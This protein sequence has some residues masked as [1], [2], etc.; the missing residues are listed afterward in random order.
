VDDP[1]ELVG[2]HFG[3]SIENLRAT[4]RWLIASAGAVVAAIIAGAQ[5]VDYS[6]RSVLGV[7]LAASAVILGLALTLILLAQTA[8]VLTVP[9]PMAT[10]LDRAEFD[11]DAGDINV[12]LSGEMN[13]KVQWII[14]RKSYLL[15]GYD[16]V[17]DLLV[18][19]KTADSE[20]QDKSDDQN[21]AAEL[22]RLERQIDIVEEAAHYR[23]LSNAYDRLIRRF[24]KGSIAFIVSVIL[25][26][27]SGIAGR[28]PDSKPSNVITQPIPVRVFI[29]APSDV[30]ASCQERDGVAIGGDL[31]KP[32]V[33]MPPTPACS[34]ATMS[35]GKSGIVIVPKVPLKGTDTPP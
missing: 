32:I 22:K 8:R 27:V 13:L 9:R 31:T 20:C 19:W 11:A 21:L 25:F 3:A 29:S 30:P 18:A 16:T 12:R 6:K 23:D 17:H 34:A 35:G 24:S 1:P 10:D 14:D 5:L 4:L 15:G 28:P 33:V 26:A 7:V 2:S